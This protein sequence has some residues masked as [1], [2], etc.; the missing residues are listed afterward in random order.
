LIGTLRET[1]LHAAL[2]QQLVQSGDRVEAPVAGFIV[3]ILRGDLII[4]VQTRG[5][6]ALKRKLPRLLDGHRVRLVHPIVVDRWIAYVDGRGRTVRRRKSPWRGRLEHLFLE[7]VSIPELIRHPNFVFVVLLVREESI[8]RAPRNPARRAGAARR[9]RRLHGRE[10]RLLEIVDRVTFASPRDYERFLP[11]GLVEPFTC[12]DLAAAT[13]H[14]LYLAQKIAYCLRKIDLIAA[15]GV[16]E[17]ATTYA[18][19]PAAP[20]ALPES[21]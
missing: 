14:P 5:F 7:L 19:R 2:K 8:R 12:R 13:G 20:A 4:E 18:V 1:S 17:R 21:S 6:T 9:S 16:R 11:A 3:D 10:R 15:A